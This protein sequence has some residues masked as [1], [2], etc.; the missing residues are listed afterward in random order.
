MNFN[1]SYLKSDTIDWYKAIKTQNIGELWSPKIKIAKSPFGRG[2][3]ATDKILP[4]D[5]LII[6]KALAFNKF[7]FI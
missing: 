1:Q 4:G 3:F 7:Q 2:L 6:E 5:I